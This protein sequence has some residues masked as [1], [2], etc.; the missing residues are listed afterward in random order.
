MSKHITK[1][2]GR[3]CSG[4]QSERKA[5]HQEHEAANLAASTVRKQREMKAGAQLTPSLVCNPGPQLMD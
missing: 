5:R 4:R 3:V 2:G 1:K